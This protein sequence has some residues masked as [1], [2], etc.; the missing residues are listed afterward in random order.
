[1]GVGK[2]VLPYLTGFL[3]IG[4]TTEDRVIKQGPHILKL[5]RLLLQLP[6]FASDFVGY[7]LRNWAFRDVN[8]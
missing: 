4:K 8:Q 1:M 2:Q 6:E 5:G 3:Y 7:S